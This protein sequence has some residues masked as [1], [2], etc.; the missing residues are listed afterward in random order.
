VFVFWAS[1]HPVYLL[2]VGE[3]LAGL[4]TVVG[5]DEGDALAGAGPVAELKADFGRL[6]LH[7]A[8]ASSASDATTTTIARTRCNPVRSSNDATTLP[9]PLRMTH[10][11]GPPTI[12]PKG[13]ADMFVKGSC[14]IRRLPHAI[15]C[16]NEGINLR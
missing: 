10:P 1:R 13:Q 5:G 9:R 14:R 3:D 16:V 11:Q 4:L 8:S 12:T 15:V 6:L 2:L 7:A